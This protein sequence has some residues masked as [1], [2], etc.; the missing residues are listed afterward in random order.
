MDSATLLCLLLSPAASLL[1][2]Q[3]PAKSRAF[4][5]WSFKKW[6]WGIKSY[7][8]RGR[9]GDEV[10]CGGVPHGEW[11]SKNLNVNGHP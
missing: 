4:T 5:F 6:A 1:L 3:S 8:G 11:L 7:R 2:Q 10:W 9:W